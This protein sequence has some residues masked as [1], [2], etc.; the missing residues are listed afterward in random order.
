MAEVMLINVF[1]VFVTKWIVAWTAQAT[2]LGLALFIPA[3]M[4]L[5]VPYFA[6][7][8]VQKPTK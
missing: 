4:L 5:F 6:H 3:L 8:V 2:N 1:L 7:A